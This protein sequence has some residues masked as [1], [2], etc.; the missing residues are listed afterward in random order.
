MG[1][2]VLPQP[3]RRVKEPYPIN[4]FK[5]PSF[6][7]LDKKS[8]AEKKHKHHHKKHHQ[9]KTKDIGD[10]GIVEEVHGFASADKSVLP[11]PWRRAKEAYPIN[12]FK[13]PS[14]NWLDKPEKKK[15]LAQKDKHHRDIGDNGI[16]EE[17]HGFASADKSVLPQP[18]RRV[19]EAYPA[20]GF[21]NPSWNWL[22]VP[23]KK[24]KSL[25]QHQHKHHHKHHHKMRAQDIGDNGIDEEVHGFAS[26]DK[27]VLPKPWRRVK[28]PYPINGFKNPSWNWLDKP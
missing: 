25:A 11:Q 28:V 4:G 15:A 7:W 12:G 16:D 6:Q 14:F 22:D 17:V 20:N 5:N 9:H 26:A 3:W 18:W 24:K 21:K 19:K 23:D 10:N 8:L 2:S 13:N 1:K 27:S